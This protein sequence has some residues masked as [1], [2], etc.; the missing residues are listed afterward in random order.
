[1]IRRPGDCGFVRYPL[2]KPA[3]DGW[4]GLSE[5]TALGGDKFAV[6]ERDNQ[7]G[8]AAALKAV[9]LI[10]AASSPGRWAAIASG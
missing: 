7:P 10:A 4:V 3:G 1:M 5:I 8:A 6:I 2:D 9:A